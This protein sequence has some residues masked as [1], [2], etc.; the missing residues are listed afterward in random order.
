VQRQE[1]YRDRSIGGEA[2]VR[3]KAEMRKREMGAMKHAKSKVKK[4]QETP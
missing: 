3:Q 1:E 2:R 4:R